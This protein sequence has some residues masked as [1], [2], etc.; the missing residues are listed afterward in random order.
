MPRNEILPEKY[1]NV[2]K[3]DKYAVFALTLLHIADNEKSVTSP[4]DGWVIAFCALMNGLTTALLQ[5][6]SRLSL[7]SLQ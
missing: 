3:Y 2:E 4:S 6:I 5:R 1:Y 7:Q